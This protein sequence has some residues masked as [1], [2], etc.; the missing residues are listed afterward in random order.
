MFSFFC[1]FLDRHWGFVVK[2]LSFEA[3]G[4]EFESNQE[5]VQYTHFIKAAKGKV[6]LYL[7]TTYSPSHFPPP[8]SHNSTGNFYLL[9]RHLRIVIVL[10]FLELVAKL[11]WIV[12]PGI[13]N[14]YEM[15]DI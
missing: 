1:S 10:Y 12:Y 2:M 3:D 6:R 4:C 8:F 13:Q 9:P 5:N 14:N 15:T 7:P 11:S